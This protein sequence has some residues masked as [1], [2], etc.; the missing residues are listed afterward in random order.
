MVDKLR[1]EVL[2]AAVDKVTGPLRAVASGS[3]ATAQAVGEA[4]FALKKLQAQ[5]R[6]LARIEQERDKLENARSM[7]EQT[8]AINLKTAKTKNLADGTERLMTVQEKNAAIQRA[9]ADYEKQVGVLKKLNAEMASRG[10]GDARMDQQQLASSIQS[11]NT[12]LDA[13]RRKLEQQRQVEE[14]LHALREKH[15]SDM[16]KLGMR[17]A[18]AAGSYMAG[19]KLARGM[20]PTVDAFMEAETAETQFKISLMQAD[21]SVAPEFQKIAEL[22]QKLGD[23][24]PGTTADFIDM[25]TTLRKEGMSTQTVLGGLGESSALLGVLLQKAPAQAAALGAKMQDALGA[26][27]SEMMGILD[28]M[29]RSHYAGADADYML[30]GFGNLAPVLSI[31]KQ[32]G[33]EAMQTLSP[34]M[35]MM[36]QAGMTD[37]SS[38]GNAIR[39]V[40]QHTMNAKKLAK[41]NAAISSAGGGFSLD[42]SDGKGEFGGQEKLFS[43]LQKLQGLNTMQRGAVMKELFGDDAETLRVLDKFI[44]KGLP[45]YQEIVKKLKEQADLQQRV[46]AQLDTLTNKA[47]AAQGSFTNMLKELGA[48]I[49]PELKDLLDWLGGMAVAVGNWVRE[50]PRLAKTMMVLVA[51]AAALLMVLGGLGMAMVAV[52]GPLA[53]VRFMAARF[54][55]GLLGA[56]VGAEGAAK[57][58]GVLSRSVGWLKASWVALRTMGIGGIFKAMGSAMASPAKWLGV[59]RGGFG[60]LWRLLTAFARANPIAALVLGLIGLFAGLYAHWDKIAEYFNAGEWWNMAKEIWAALEWGF[61]AATL[62]LYDLLKSVVMSAL[63]AVW[64]GIKEIVGYG[65]KATGAPGANTARAATAAAA[66]ATALPLMAGA[67]AARI[68]T[69]Q[70]TLMAPK[71]SAAPASTTTNNISIQAAP[72]MDEKALARAVTFEMDKRQRTADARRYSRLSDID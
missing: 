1:L 57:G 2:L 45:G 12:Q 72:G 6:A 71:A 8:Q 49:A 32:K 14:R 46:N 69:Y 21:G 40:Y 42:F 67:D 37:G 65:E 30:A 51:G 43:E 35:V 19:Q 62:G 38:A 60:G 22:A 5:Q 54:G 36:N 3:K 50:N 33:L 16:A 18:M 11:T 63:S 28:M 31:I 52:L 34:M 41:A 58:L 10:M 29:Q 15:G 9:T 61:N 7:M 27:E 47:E 70:P 55:L 26:S 39:K 25:M 20:M 68:D 56:K 66:M 44:E 4:E 17:G 53:I 48:T 23:R 24:L 13:Q 64:D 59:L